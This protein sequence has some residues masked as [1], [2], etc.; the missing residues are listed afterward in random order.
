MIIAQN[1]RAYHDYVILKE[2]EAGIELIGPE[3]KSI[4]A[5]RVN[6]SHSFIKIEEN[7]AFLFNAH[8]NP[9]EYTHNIVYDPKRKRKLLLKRREI[10]NLIKK[11][12][13]KGLTIVPLKLY[14]KNSWVKI[15]IALARGKS[16]FDKRETLKKKIFQRE[17]DREHKYEKRK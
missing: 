8:I 17:I 3:V 2:I 5:H 11:T 15:L 14:F 9:Y 16:K 7:E 1:K 4:R 13:E 10:A 6:I 12:D